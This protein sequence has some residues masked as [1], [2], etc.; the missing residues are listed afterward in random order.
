LHTSFDADAVEVLEVEVL[1][2]SLRDALRM[3]SFA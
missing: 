3:T 2:A 1:R